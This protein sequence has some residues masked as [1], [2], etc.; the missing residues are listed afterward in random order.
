M[1][2]AFAIDD[3]AL[4]LGAMS[5]GREFDWIRG[6]RLT[7]GS[8]SDPEYA[9]ALEELQKPHRGI[10]AAAPDSEEA[11]RIRRDTAD[12]AISQVIVKRWTRHGEDLEVTPESVYQHL[13]DPRFAHLREFIVL[14]AASHFLTEAAADETDAGNSEGTS[15]GG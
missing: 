1:T 9:K 7:L 12:R 6:H 8:F 15:A 10:L 5:S 11:K 13:R 2:K 14:H 3:C 4:D